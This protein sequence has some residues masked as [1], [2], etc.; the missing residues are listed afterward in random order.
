MDQ[1]YIINAVPRSKA[2]SIVRKGSEVYPGN[3]YMTLVLCKN[4][5]GEFEPY[6]SNYGSELGVISL[7]RKYGVYG[8]YNT[9]D[10]AIKAY[11]NSVKAFESKQGEIDLLSKKLKL[12]RKEQLSARE[13][14]F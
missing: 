3:F 2:V 12:L 8:P 14:A 5:L 13:A 4:H 11:K 1:F 6:N 10:E 9:T 7:E